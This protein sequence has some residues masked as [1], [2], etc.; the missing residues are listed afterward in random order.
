[1]AVSMFKKKKVQPAAAWLVGG[2]AIGAAPAIAQAQRPARGSDG[3]A[4]Q[5]HGHRDC[6]TGADLDARGHRAHRQVVIQAVLRVS[7]STAWARS[8]VVYQRIRKRLVRRLA[9]R[10]GCQLDA[11]AGERPSHDDLWPGRRRHAQ[12]RRPQLVA[13]G[14]RRAH[15]SAEGRR[16]GHLRRRR[17]G[18]RGQRHPAQELHRRHDRWL[19]WPG[20]RGRWPDGARIRHVGF[21][22]L[23]TDKYNVFFTLEAS[24]QKN[25]WSVDRGFIGEADLTSLGYYD[26]H[27]RRP[28]SVFRS[29][30]RRPTRPTARHASL[31]PAHG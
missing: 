11:G 2:L 9:A 12:L 8:R 3:F 30:R 28:S 19:V 10:P 14:G 31:A 17:G 21:G 7:P 20:Q 5:A 23:D 24:K 25:I 15:R 26:T 22:N 6:I 13:P 4:H 16:I 29:R 27:Q 1:M 18:R